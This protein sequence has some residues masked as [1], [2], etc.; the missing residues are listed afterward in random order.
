MYVGVFLKIEVDAYQMSELEA[1][2][3]SFVEWIKVV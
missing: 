1:T 3:S 2:S